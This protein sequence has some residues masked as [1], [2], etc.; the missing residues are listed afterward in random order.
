MLTMMKVAAIRQWLWES[1]GQKFAS[2]SEMPTMGY[3]CDKARAGRNDYAIYALNEEHEMLTAFA[4]I[5]RDK[6]LES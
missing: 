3:S 2:R 6:R 1:V 4:I 5:R